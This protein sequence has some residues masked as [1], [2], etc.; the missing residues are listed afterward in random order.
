MKCKDN[1]NSGMMRIY[2]KE[3]QTAFKIYQSYL[4]S[5]LYFNRLTEIFIYMWK[6]ENPY[7][8]FRTREI[9]RVY[10]GMMR[11]NVSEPK[12]T[13]LPVGLG[14]RET[15]RGGPGA[16]RAY[17]LPEGETGMFR[18]RK[19]RQVRSLGRTI[20]VPARKCSR[21]SAN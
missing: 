12:P 15:R 9:V 3:T 16:R 1:T 20:S 2:V 6:R 13:A 14:C 5:M 19:R 11:K 7:K 18:I 17:P 4:D 10:P 21:S 8:W